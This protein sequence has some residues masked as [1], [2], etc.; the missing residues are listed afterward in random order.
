M[1]S[2]VVADN[3]AQVQRAAR[4]IQATFPG[5]DL[6]TAE[7]WLAAMLDFSGPFALYLASDNTGLQYSKHYARN[8]VRQTSTTA[9]FQAR[10]LA[11]R[12]NVGL[13]EA[14]ACVEQLTGEAADET[15][16]REGALWGDALRWHNQGDLGRAISAAIAAFNRQP[17]SPLADIGRLI[18]RSALAARPAPARLAEL[19]NLAADRGA[20]EHAYDW[21]TYLTGT[22]TTRAHFA[23]AE[24]Y[25]QRAI[26]QSRSPRIRAASLVNY[27]A[28]L[29]DGRT[30]GVPDPVRALA[31]FEEA[32]SMGMVLGMLNAASV[33]SALANDGDAAYIERAA[34]WFQHALD[35]VHAGKIVLDFNGEAALT[36]HLDQCRLGL[37]YM[38][39]Y[40]TFSRADA[41]AGIALIA[42]L[43]KAGN[44]QARSLTAVGEARKAARVE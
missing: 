38:H 13:A 39:V 3:A 36:D 24:T 14:A 10:V 15:L 28:L 42:A 16:L 7:H 8:S 35:Y 1:E 41:A 11:E 9:D 26:S 18:T 32:A 37:A 4:C 22:A 6:E 5:A 23:I 25:F 20:P 44:A 34:H 30:A 31:L 12:A 17:A 2:N 19:L 33:C 29:R 43:H 27:A 40:G 21:A